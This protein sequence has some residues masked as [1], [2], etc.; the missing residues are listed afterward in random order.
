MKPDIL[1]NKKLTDAELERIGSFGSE[2]FP[3]VFAI[4]GDVSG[5]GQYSRSVFAAAENE[6]FVFDLDR[7]DPPYSLRFSDIQKIFTKRMY[8]NAFIRVILK[9]EDKPRNIFR[10]TLSIAQ[11][12]DSA[13]LFVKNIIGGADPSEQAEIIAARLNT[14]PASAYIILPGLLKVKPTS[15]MRTR[16]TA[17]VPAA[18]TV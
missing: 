10:Y 11:L 17:A 15:T 1:V 18:P 2:E 7:N 14:P 8:G 6:L 3:I 13:I 16:A 4:V 5:E 9:G 12:C